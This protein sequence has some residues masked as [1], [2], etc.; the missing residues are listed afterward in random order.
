MTEQDEPT[1]LQWAREEFPH[2]TPRI[3]SDN[4]SQFLARNF[5]EYI[6]ICGM[7]H[8]RTSPYYPQSNGTLERFHGSIMGECLRPGTPL[9]LTTP[10][11]KN[12]ALLTN[13]STVTILTRQAT[14]PFQG[15]PRQNHL[16]VLR[17]AGCRRDGTRNWW[18]RR[19]RGRSGL[20][21]WRGREK[22]QAPTAKD[23][24]RKLGNKDLNLD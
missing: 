15:E 3:S 1:V 2:E 18:P 11:R 12:Q 4:G 13:F 20:R 7:T 9:S 5:K 16:A 6:R 19:W 23:L 17:L 10:K 14:F 8:V 24:K 22:A 21:L